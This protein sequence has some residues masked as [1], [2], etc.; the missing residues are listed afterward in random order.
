MSDPMY[1]QWP[2]TTPGTQ[3]GVGPHRSV[4]SLLYNK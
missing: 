2:Q 4:Y 3:C 1:F